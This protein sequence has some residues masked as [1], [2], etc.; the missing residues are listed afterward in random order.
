MLKSPEQWLEETAPP[1]KRGLFKVFLGYAPGVGKTYSMLSEG[2]RRHSRG[3]DVVIGVVETHGRAATAELANRLE[4]VTRKQLEYKG[5][6]FDE[7]NVDAVLSRNP[8]VALV[9]E[10]AHTNVDGSKHRKRYEDIME[11]LDA[12][13]DVIS[14]MN[15]QH[16]ESVTPLITRIT[17]VIVRE[18][19]PDWVMQR[20]DE[21]VLSDLTPEALRNRMKRGDIYPLERAERAL[22]N[23]FRPGNLIALREVALQQVSRVVDQTLESYLEKEHIEKRAPITEKIAVCISSNPAAQYLMARAS[24]MAN[25]IDAEFYVIYVDVGMD[26][27]PENRRTLQDNFRFADNLGAQIVRTAGKNVAQEVANI[28]R[29]KHVTQVVFGRS[30]VKGWKKYL[31]LSAIHKFLRDTPSVDVH[32]VT[33]EAR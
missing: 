33:Q 11:L 7:M 12:N 14:T 2:I 8:N 28:I 5:T 19:V 16:I 13:I 25:R 6:V 4:V 30:A 31:Y 26:D 24:R 32:I 3:E 20:V 17:G 9:D 18:T 10:L 1:K 27:T 22:T 15:V 21:V 29:E 23:F